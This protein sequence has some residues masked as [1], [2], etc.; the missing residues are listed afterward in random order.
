[1]VLDQG[2]QQPLPGVNVSIGGTTT[3]TS[4]DEDGRFTLMDV[5][6]GV[7]DIHLSMV[8]YE[9]VILNG[10]GV[11]QDA[12]VDLGTIAMRSTAISLSEII[13]TPGQFSIMGSAELSRQV[14]SSED[15]QNMSWA[16]DVTRAVARLPGISSSDYSSKFTIRGGE[17]DEVLISLDGMEL[18]EPFHQRDYS[19]GLF[20]IVDIAAIDGIDLMTGGYSSEYGNRLSGVFNMRTKQPVAGQ[21]NTS[22]GL[23]ILNASVYT[24]GTFGEGRG[25]YILSARRGM[26]DVLFSVFGAAEEAT[27]DQGSTPKFYD[28]LA[29]IEYRLTPKHRLSVHAL[30]A[31]DRN[32]V[33]DEEGINFDKNDTRYGNTYGWVTLNSMHSDNL[34]SRSIL[35]SGYIT[36]DRSGS[37]N[38]Y[39]PS[40]KGF[41]DLTDKRDY[42]LF[43]VKQDWTWKATENLFIS[44]GFEG[45]L[46]S[47][48]YD[49]FSQLEEIRV[50]TNE[51]AYDFAN[52]TD[53]EVSPS[54][55]QL[56]VYATGRFK[57]L[58]KLVAE[59]GLRY[60]KSTYSNDDVVSP[61]LGLAY[62][63]SRKTVVRAAWGYYYQSQFINDLDV[64]HGTTE[65]NQAEL[66]K[67]YVLGVEHEVAPGFELRAEGYYKDLSNY[68]PAW[69]NLRD[70][71]EIFPEARNDNA[72]VV[73]S[74]A[75]SMGIE[76]F[77]KYDRGGKVSW[78]LSYAVAK[79]EDIVSSIEYDGQLTK[80]LGNVPRLNNQRHT[81]YADINYRPGRN[82]HLNLSW[83]Y[84]KGWPR[85]D[86]TYDYIALDNGDLHFYAV[87]QEFNQTEYPAFHR[88]DLRTNRQFNTRRGKITTYLHL[89]NVYNHENLKKFDLDTRD[90]AGNF[91]LDESGNYVQFR[92][93]KYWFGFVP[94]V[95]AKWQF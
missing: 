57:I 90:D 92:D 67:H 3:G 1:M 75:E 69:Q 27:I 59:T 61:R 11:A 47:A 4:T 2:T 65:F 60:D 41:F 77:T 64:N 7:Y 39:E 70:H 93:D 22:V 13:V 18:Y 72:L 82:W 38:K 87:H 44:S 91:S 16:E 36:H 49:Y 40:D 29:K 73:R 62:A 10:I 32:S 54:G 52:T 25:S 37:F 45:K 21:R 80:V 53:L 6:G 89:I 17:S 26:L 19:G 66:A 58:P 83:T 31:G 86:Y 15:I 88:M 14:L 74:G 68:S 51:V 9:S 81:V 34:F 35:Y 71:L 42:S 78:W 63:I 28:A 5:Q 23:S 85:T 56:G 46:L 79:A 50:D 76:L 48:K 43:G 20:S 84:Y 12:R 95:G 33:L 8:G 94:V 55:Q 24:D 30:R